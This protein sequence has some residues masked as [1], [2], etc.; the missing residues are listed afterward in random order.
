MTD[1]AYVRSL[2]AAEFLLTQPSVKGIPL[3]RGHG[4]RAVHLLVQR[5]ATLAAARHPVKVV[6]HPFLASASRNREVFG[7]YDNVYELLDVQG[8]A[9][10]QM[11]SDNIVPNTAL[12][13]RKEAPESLIAVGPVVR[14]APGKTPPL[15]RDKHIWPVVELNEVCS[16]EQSEQAL[17]F[18]RAVLEDLLRSA[19]IPALTIETPALAAYGKKTYL[20]VSALPNRRP[21]VL[22]TLYVL[23]DRLRAA[24]SDGDE[25]VDVGFTGKVFATAAMLHED[26]R[27]LVLTSSTAPVQL[28][29]IAAGSTP[30]GTLDRWLKAL[31][32]AGVRCRVEVAHPGTS[33]RDRAERRFLRRGTPLVIGLD[34]TPGAIVACTRQPLSRTTLRSLPSPA[35][36]ITLLND[37]DDRVYRSAR[38][39]FDRTMHGNGHL[40]TLCDPCA[41]TAELPVFGTVVPEVRQ[42]CE[43]C[44]EPTGR[45]LFISEEGRFY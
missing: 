9:D 20:T 17:D 41:D 31:D 10:L 7:E 43:T 14:D 11:R 3:W 12:L 34:R 35:E 1:A 19:G 28:G 22:A 23:A 4:I 16:Q 40:R 8:D 21:T 44:T 37:H 2:G 26:G 29:V 33:A 18:Y 6:E 42:P 15:F 36:V 45:Q 5:F 25:V 24:L 13:R 32:D 30:P 39:V 38:Q 27:G